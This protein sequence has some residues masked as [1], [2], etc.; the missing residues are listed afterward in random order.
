MS[1]RRVPRLRRG[2]IVSHGAARRSGSAKRSRTLKLLEQ[3]LA[4]GRKVL[5][6]RRSRL[7]H[8]RLSVRSD[9]D[10]C[11]ERNVA[12]DE[13]GLKRRWRRSASVR[14]PR[15]VQGRREAEYAGQRSAFRGYDL[16]PPSRV[17]AL[18]KEGSAVPSLTA[19]NAA[20][21]RSETVLRG[22]GGQ[23]GDRAS[24]RRAA[25]LTPS[26]WTIRKRSSRRSSPFG[27]VVT[28][29]LAVGDRLPQSIGR[30]ARDDAQPLRDAPHARHCATCWGQC[31]A[32]RLA[33][34]PRQDAL[35]LRAWRAADRRRDPPHRGSSTEISRTT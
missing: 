28:G 1:G 20:S 26:P 32:A 29:E 34:R 15:P 2:P 16:C 25:C 4:G 7:R 14:A 3:A 23:V 27:V 35:R 11:R 8:V 13:A 12:V 6:A 18:Y 33:R 10:V 30:R 9:A 22:S 31:A 17:T 5:D 21:S 19:G 24:L